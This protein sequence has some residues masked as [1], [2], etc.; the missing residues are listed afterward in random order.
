MSAQLLITVLAKNFFAAYNTSERSKD[1]FLI[2]ITKQKPPS[3]SGGTDPRGLRYL[4]RSCGSIVA[5]L[6]EVLEPIVYCARYGALNDSLNELSKDLPHR[7][8][9]LS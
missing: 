4:L 7:Y 6:E 8:H 1:N 9:H 2:V 3:K 5:I